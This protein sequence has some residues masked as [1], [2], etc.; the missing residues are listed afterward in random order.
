MSIK[1]ISKFKRKR[2]KLSEVR[3]R[4]RLKFKVKIPVAEDLVSMRKIENL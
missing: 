2:R 4:K 3:S 1:E